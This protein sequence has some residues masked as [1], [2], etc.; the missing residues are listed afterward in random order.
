MAGSAMA[1][2]IGTMKVTEQVDAMK[3]LK[4]DPIGYLIVPRILAGCFIMPFVIVLAN[5]V[6][7]LGG[8][9]TSHIV[10]GLSVLNY[11]DSVWEG[12][13]QKDIFVSLLKASIFGGI[14]ALVSSSMGYKTR[15]G[16]MDVGKATT[17]A[18]VWSF[19]CVVIV[20]YIISMLFFQ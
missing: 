16:A 1:A 20:D 4:V 12:L 10:S 19:V 14:I 11:V 15:G 7:I 3:T 8:L 6:G 9:I 13:S 18:V 5:A 2:E 17:N